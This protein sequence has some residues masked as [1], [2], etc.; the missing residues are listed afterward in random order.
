VKVKFTGGDFGGFEVTQKHFTH[1][2]NRST[3]VFDVPSPTFGFGPVALAFWGYVAVALAIMVASHELGVPTDMAVFVFIGV[4][5][6][7]F[8]VFLPLFRRLMPGGRVDE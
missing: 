8:P 1:R 4:S 3:M 5:V 2:V 6:L 7:L